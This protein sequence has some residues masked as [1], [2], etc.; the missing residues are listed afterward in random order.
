MIHRAIASLICRAWENTLWLQCDK[1]VNGPWPG[2]YRPPFRKVI[3]MYVMIFSNSDRFLNKV[4]S[5]DHVVL[6]HLFQFLNKLVQSD[7]VLEL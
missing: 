3:V 6:A 5:V 7:G 1:Y 2:G 4:I